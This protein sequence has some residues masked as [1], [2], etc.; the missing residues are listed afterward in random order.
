MTVEMC[1]LLGKTIILLP[2]DRAGDIS[3]AGVGLFF[4]EP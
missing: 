3:F 1:F 4:S 2:S